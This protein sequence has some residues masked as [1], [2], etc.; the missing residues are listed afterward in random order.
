MPTGRLSRLARFGGMATGIAGG[1][2]I[3]GAREIARG[4]R[5]KLGDLLMTPGNAAKVTQQLA[6]LRGA[7]MKMGQ[8]MSMDAGDLLP[9]ELTDIL[10]RL[11]ADAESMPYAQLRGVLDRAWG[12]GWR[13]RFTVFD[14]RPIAAASIGQVHRATLPDGRL[15][16]IK[17]QY[18]GVRAS[19]DSD[20]DNV[21]GLL[22]L[23]NLLPRTLDIAPMLAEAKRQ[24]HE[25]ANYA[26]EAAYLTRYRAL[27]ADLP[28]FAV[29]E[30][31]PE[32][33]TPDVLAM[34][35]ME[36]VH[37]E[38]LAEAPQAVRDAAMTRLIDLV[39]RELFDFG[40]M[41]TDPNFANYL[42]DAAG[43][44]LVLLDF[45]ATREIP[46]GLAD[47]YRRLARAGLAG[48]QAQIWAI[49]TE[50]GFV[51][52]SV[53]D[54]YRRR[55]LAMAEL[56]VA[57]LR[58]GGP[59]DFGRNDIAI[60]L[61]DEGLALAADRALWHIPPPETLFVQRKLGGMYLLASRLKAR[62]NVAALLARW[63]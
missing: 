3:D 38:R 57:P 44:R 4:N 33:T 32:L 55:I 5:P 34:T 50:L 59:F 45:G 41:Q 35:F 20:V 27:L 9:R 42:W 25:E 31:A 29:P 23:S 39:L 37:I 56:A 61:R 54:Q 11:R 22:K 52:P 2:L 63:L 30:V 46:A 17:V 14:I 51:A 62:V 13:E 18:P 40:L 19:I 36:G 16:A 1:L 47:G 48:D 12:P 49:A 43:E 6:N 21:A 58:D 8:L 26:R 10:A 28:G 24:L 15:L 53:P 7:A 60:R